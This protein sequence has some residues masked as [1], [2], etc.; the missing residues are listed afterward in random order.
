MTDLTLNDGRT[1][2]QLGLG[3]WQIPDPQAAAIVR[4]G[5]D[6]GYRL[7]D[8]AAFYGNE[9]GVGDGVKASDIWVTTKL[10]N[11]RQDDVEAALDESLALL[12]RDSVDLY[13]MHWPVPAAGLYVEA[14][15]AMVRLREAG[16]A[17]SIGVSNF[18]P[19]HL[20]AIVQATGV[21]PVVNQIELHP[22][23]QQRD[24]VAYHQAHGIVT[25]SWSPIGQGKALLADPRI[26]AIA[27]RYGR[28]AAQ[29]VI[30]WHLAKGYSVIPKASSAEH[31][32]DNLAAADWQ[33]SEDDIA[34]ID[35]LDS[36]DGRL[37]P[38]PREM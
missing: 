38:D 15:K 24:C 6:L 1:M 28:S 37:G 10:W 13:L 33:L 11:D 20:D 17:L 21:I 25:Q 32:S 35:G 12:G 36:A 16:K 34:A 4:K 27:E 31:L 8:T 18:L 30:A 26:T 2:P 23:F 14:W 29:V 5:I 3:T 7:V 22:T 9:R 19:E